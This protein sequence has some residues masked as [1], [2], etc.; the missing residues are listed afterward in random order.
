M[1]RLVSLLL[2]AAS[3]APPS[4]TPTGG[5][6][7]ALAPH[8]RA[9]SGAA[10]SH[11]RVTGAAER[12]APGVGRASLPLELVVDAPLP[13][14][15]VRFDYLELDRTTKNLVIAHMNDASV[16]VVRAGDGSLVKRVSSVP[17]PRGVA[18]ADDAGR[19]FVSSSP[20]ALVI[21]DRRSLT[22][23]ARVTTGTAPDGVAWDGTDRI[24]AVS[25][26]GD[27]AVSLIAQSGSGARTQVQ[28]GGEPGNVVFDARRRAFWVTVATTSAPDRLVALDPLEAR[29]TESV[30]LG[31][32]SG[33]HGLRLHPNG[34]SAFVACER[35]SKVVR[36][37]LASRSHDQRVASCGRH[38]DV[39]AIDAGLGWL[40][41]ASE[42][43]DLRVFDLGQ[44]GL[45]QIAE[46]HPG[47]GSHSLAVDPETHRVY[48]PLPR[49]PLGAPVLRIMKPSGT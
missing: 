24:V 26:Q 46:Q 33:A 25:D 41:V 21:L 42:S 15:A 3:C 29:I 14:R 49:G 23:I 39:M 17:I 5:A 40:Y 11:A 4:A 16:L 7:A 18:I 31:H 2:F 13:G 28:L 37:D 48:F 34:P 22:E 9:E 38:P 10:R 32:C 30:A 36:V 27:G 47:D 12:D 44:P 6:P 19:I 8:A 43:G 20:H 45:V 1:R 35:N